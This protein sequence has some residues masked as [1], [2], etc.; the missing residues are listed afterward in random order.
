MKTTLKNKKRSKR[1]TKRKGVEDRMQA[2]IRSHWRSRKS[3]KT[4]AMYCSMVLVST[5]AIYFLEHASL[6]NAFRT[7]LVAAIG[8]TFAA[9]WVAGIFD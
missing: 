2:G 7:A 9:V 6:F 4:F 5:A 8:K 3:A 1:R